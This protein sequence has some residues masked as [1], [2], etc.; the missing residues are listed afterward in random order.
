M[1]VAQKFVLFVSV[2]IAITVNGSVG[3]SEIDIVKGLN[4]KLGDFPM[5]VALNRCREPFM[6]LCAEYEFGGT[7]IILSRK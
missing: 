4:A 1:N 6:T 7:G 3:N 2:I 5:V